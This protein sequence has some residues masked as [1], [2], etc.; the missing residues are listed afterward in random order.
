MQS[1]R[2][3]ICEGRER[4]LLLAKMKVR[5]LDKKT[6]YREKDL[7][8]GWKLYLASDIED[9]V[10]GGY[11]TVFE[12]RLKAFHFSEKPNAEDIKVLDIDNALF[13]M[14]FN[15]Q[16]YDFV[17]VY[18]FKEREVTVHYADYYPLSYTGCANKLAVIKNAFPKVQTTTET[19]DHLKQ[20]HASLVRFGD[21]EFNLCLGQSIGFQ[22]HSEALQSRLLEVLF[23]PKTD[24]LVVAIPEFNSQTNNKP[25]C[26]GE[27]SFW[28]H[29]W[30]KTFRTVGNFLVRDSYGNANISRNSV[31]AENPLEAVKA[32]WNNRDVVFVYGAGSRFEVKGELFDNVA[33]YTII[34]TLP[35][36]AFDDYGRLLGACLEQP[37]PRLFLIACGPTATVLAY[38]LMKA[39]YQA[40]DIGHLPNCYDQHLG[41]IE[42][43][44]LLP[45]TKE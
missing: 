22:T 11:L 34:E 28:E 26:I 30:Y 23:S 36:N 18:T 2:L 40:L 42:S 43:P 37:L 6:T 3:D 13:C 15:Q 39:G 8:W 16:L 38:D 9:F 10:S 27:L 33:S 29:Y 1:L 32:L 25:R 21:G 45:Y 19:L 5:Q 35:T 44:E 24:K 14:V 12:M 41:R 20:Y 17:M 7:G 4:D 31:F